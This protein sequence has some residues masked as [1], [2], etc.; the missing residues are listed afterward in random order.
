MPFRSIRYIVAT[1]EDIARM[2]SA[3]EDAWAQIQRRKPAH[4]LSVAEERERLGYIVVRVWEEKPGCD[5][6]TAA[7]CQF[8]ATAV[9]SA[10][11]AELSKARNL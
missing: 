2:T 4:V 5:L 3:L 1:R 7:A 9:T 10:S 6:A 8:L 11:L